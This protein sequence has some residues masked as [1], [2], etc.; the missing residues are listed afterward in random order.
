MTQHGIPGKTNNKRKKRET[1]I[2]K[3]KTEEKTK[4]KAQRRAK[5]QLDFCRKFEVYRV[6]QKWGEVSREDIA[7]ERIKKSVCAGESDESSSSTRVNLKSCIKPLYSLC[8]DLAED[9]DSFTEELLRQLPRLLNSR[10]QKTD[11]SMWSQLIRPRTF[12][13]IGRET[14]INRLAAFIYM[15][16]NLESICLEGLSLKPGEGIRLLT[17][18]YN[19]RGTMKYA[20][21]WRAFDKTVGIPT[22]DRYQAESRFCPAKNLEKC[23]WFRAIGCLACL[24]TLSI[25][26]AYIATPTGDLL[27]SLAKKLRENWKWLQLLCL[28]EEITRNRDGDAILIP[29][30]A[31]MKAHGLATKLKIQYAII[32]I[33]EHDVHKLFLTK[34]TRVHTFALTTGIDLR[35][36]QPWCLDLTIKTIC[37]WYPD[38]L[39]YLC[40]RFWHN[41]ENLDVQLKKIFLDLPCL[42]VFEYT[43]EIRMLKT[44][45]A[46][47]CQIR[48][49]KCKVCRVNMELQKVIH[50]DIDEEKWIKSING[51]MV[52]FKRDFDK[53]GVKFDVSFC[54]C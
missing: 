29:E 49:N 15:Q 41:R 30:Y 44:L 12:D 38:T 47:C 50:E 17:A 5:L 8:F 4:A 48:S 19:S 33:P 42:R 10:K 11:V 28:R 13:F 45:C 24:T 3:T 6:R 31:W 18:L 22:N 21:C 27:I 37:S 16:N 20:Y 43:G 40:F 23:D 53:M 51:L 25:N 34:Q 32:G 54:D 26:Y 35:F 52:C 7:P 14:L 36:R 46:M 2:A 1:K 39:V 9:Q